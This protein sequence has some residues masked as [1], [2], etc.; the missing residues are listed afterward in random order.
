[1]P[2]PVDSLLETLRDRQSYMNAIMSNI[3]PVALIALVISLVALAATVLQLLQQYFA[4]ADGYRR[5]QPG[6]MGKWGT[7]TTTRIVWR[8]LRYE[9]IYYVPNFSVD[10]FPQPPAESAH[11]WK[12]KW[13]NMALTSSYVIYKEQELCDKMKENGKPHLVLVYVSDTAP[14]H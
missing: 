5:C 13:S 1:V 2:Q 7:K 4:T 3:D 9:T 14:F 12:K 8:E 11:I 6:V 10:I